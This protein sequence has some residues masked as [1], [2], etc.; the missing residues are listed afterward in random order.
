MDIT[1]FVLQ[2]KNITDKLINTIPFIIQNK[3]WYGFFKHRIVLT[4]SIITAIVVPFSFFNFIS[5][6]LQSLAK[7]STPQLLASTSS[8]QNI[9]FNKLFEGTH[10]YLLMILVHLLNIYFSNK[11]IERLSGVTIDL[12]VKEMI[13]SYFRNLKV[14]VRTWFTELVLGI[15]ISI[16][17]GIFGPDWMVDTL[18]FLLG[19]YF[20]G[21]IFIDN[22]NATFAI[23]INNSFQIIKHH[24]G[25]AISLGLVAKILLLIP[26]IGIILTSFICGVAATWYMHT[27][28]DKQES[29]LAFVE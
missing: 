26:F 5:D 4:I 9:N 21:Y 18:K 14:I 27:S 24:A 12:S 10:T 16:I 2:V 15:G 6:Y 1:T 13:Y 3:L 11:T 20:L 19:C 23:S 17:V 25:A 22:Y 8:D 7:V 29:T 28:A